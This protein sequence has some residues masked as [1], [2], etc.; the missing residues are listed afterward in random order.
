M[1][2]GAWPTAWPD[3]LLLRP[4]L[5]EPLGTEVI[6][7]TAWRRLRPTASQGSAA[8]S[9]QNALKYVGDRHEDDQSNKEYLTHS[10]LS[11][12]KSD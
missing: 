3:V 4:S 1:V 6:Q 12:F 10:S 11:G 5:K 8:F 7:F 9:S 2:W